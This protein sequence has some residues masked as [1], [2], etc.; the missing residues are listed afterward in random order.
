MFSSF[1]STSE[2]V[3]FHSVLIC[4]QVASSTEITRL[5]AQVVNAAFFLGTVYHLTDHW[6]NSGSLVRSEPVARH[7]TALHCTALHCPHRGGNSQEPTSLSSSS[8]SS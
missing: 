1:V 8:S 3:Y 4:V 5:A 6:R 7:F 2:F